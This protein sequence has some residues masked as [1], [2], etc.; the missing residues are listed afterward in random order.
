MIINTRLFPV[1]EGL[2]MRR[3]LKLEKG[4]DAAINLAN[5]LAPFYNKKLFSEEFVVEGTLENP[6]IILR[7]PGERR[8][9]RYTLC[10]EKNQSRLKVRWLNIFDFFVETYAN[11]EKMDSGIFSYWNLADDFYSNKRE[12]EEFWSLLD[13]IY[14]KE[15]FS[16]DFPELPGINSELF[17]L[18]LKWMWVQEE[19]NYTTLIE[20][21]QI[22][23]ELPK[24]DLH[25]IKW[26]KIDNKKV[27]VISTSKVRGIGRKA[28]YAPLLLMKFHNYI[29]K[30]VKKIIRFS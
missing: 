13:K 8:I 1:V 16:T 14:N 24:Y 6:K 15:D 4:G 27:R 19:L 17:L 30:E 21:H 3:L 10:L 29:P 25:K 23:N 2:N 11:G 7:Y 12:S 26:E 20:P 28:F 22:E 9:D 18:T 5:K